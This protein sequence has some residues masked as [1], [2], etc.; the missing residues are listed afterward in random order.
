M[1][2]DANLTQQ[3]Q[4]QVLHATCK[5][6]E[7]NVYKFK[8][9]GKVLITTPEH[10][11]PVLCDGKIQLL[12]AQ[13]IHKSD[14]LYVLHSVSFVACEIE[15]ISVE[16][17]Q[18]NVYNVELLSNTQTTSDDLFWIAN[19]VVTHNCFPKDINSLIHLAKQLGVDPKVMNG[20]WQKNLEVRPQRDWEKLKG[21]AISEGET[22]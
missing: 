19:G 15:E 7:G 4:K 16:E 22:K 17:Y 13:Q 20:A 1:S 12:M 14:K 18:G 9:G 2:T 11:F 10:F 5:K 8:V 21:R 6:Y 3:E